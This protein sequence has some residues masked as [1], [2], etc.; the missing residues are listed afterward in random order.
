MNG[1][2]IAAI[3]QAVAAIIRALTALI[4]SAYTNGW[5]LIITL[6]DITAS[7]AAAATEWD[8]SKVQTVVDYCNTKPIPV[9]TIGEV[10]TA[11]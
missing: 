2:A 5:W 1:A 6:H 3:I 9:R 7:G 8:V 11:T 4:D 10:L